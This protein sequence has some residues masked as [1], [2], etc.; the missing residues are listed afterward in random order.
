M[1]SAKQCDRISKTGVASLAQHCCNP[2][3]TKLILL[4]QHCKC[5]HTQAA[6]LLSCCKRER[7]LLWSTKLTS[8]S[9][10]W[11]S[12]CMSSLM[13]YCTSRLGR[14]GCIAFLSAASSNIAF[15]AEPHTEGVK[16]KHD[17]AAVCRFAQ[18]CCRMQCQD[19][20]RTCFSLGTT[21]N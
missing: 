4:E 6:V 13:T 8:Q 14:A 7:V 1:Q 5:W 21:W 12:L 15:L 19:S 9:L 2:T 10:E 18:Q 11:C 16:C 20:L 3:Q 17:F